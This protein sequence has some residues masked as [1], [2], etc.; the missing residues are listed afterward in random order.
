MITNR[1]ELHV[2]N[3]IAEVIFSCPEKMNALTMASFYQLDSIIKQ[4]KRM[5]N[6]RLV[7]LK[8][9]G[10]NFCA[11]LD[12]KSVSTKPS[13]II[14][15]LFKWLPGNANLAQRV[16]IGWQQLS[17]PVI[18]EIKGVCFGGGLQ[19]AMGAD[20]RLVDTSARLAIMETKWGL[21]PD[22]GASS[23]LSKLVNLDKALLLTH[24]ATPIDAQTAFE[25]GLVTKVCDDL[26]HATHELSQQLLAQSPD[27]LA[28]NKRLYQTSYG[29]M[30]RKALAKETINQIRLLM[31]KNRVI[32]AK[33]VLSDQD[34]S[35]QAPKK[36]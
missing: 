12:V 8:A 21:C 25:Y 23:A 7:V 16:C 11:G 24:L 26:T 1:I 13:N 18:A 31:G 29:V 33:R 32:A 27:A 14:K 2:K 9:E 6:L 20:F 36:W 17:V 30:S 34:I 10:D 3:E 5:P 28:A 35:Y 4:L 15:L 19:I 22:M